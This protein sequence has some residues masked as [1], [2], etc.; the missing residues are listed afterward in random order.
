MI[1]LTTNTLRN[2]LFT[3]FI[4]TAP[5]LRFL[6]LT[7]RPSNINKYIPAAWK[8]APPPNVYFGTSVVSQKTVDKLVPQLLQVKG[9]KFLS[10]EP[11]L[12]E[13]DLTPFLK[14][15]D[16]IIVG[17]ESGPKRRPFNPDWA[18]KIRDDCKKA[19]TP[20]F[21]KQWDNVKEIPEDLMIREFPKDEKETVINQKQNTMKKQKK[22][23]A[24]IKASHKKSNTV[25]PELIQAE[26]REPE[27]SMP[28]SEFIDLLRSLTGLPIKNI[29]YDNLYKVLEKELMKYDDVVFS[30]NISPEDAREINLYATLFN[31]LPTI[32]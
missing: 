2:E 15:L 14:D 17:G 24:E 3:N 25:L 21:M 13:V 30:E 27:F 4:P 5:N 1:E 28:K 11:L 7:K 16:Q 29:K 26:N 8:V 31:N 23:E 32:Q 9:R 18:R 10:V 20:F 22:T 12:E 19:G 6:L